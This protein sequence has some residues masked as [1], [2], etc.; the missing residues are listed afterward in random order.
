VPY[1]Q[2]RRDIL[3][4]QLLPGNNIGL[5]LA[6]AAVG[7]SASLAQRWRQAARLTT[8]GDR[9]ANALLCVVHVSVIVM[10]MICVGLPVWKMA[11]LGARGEAYRVSSAAHTWIFAA[12][13]LYWPW[14]RGSVNRVA[15]RFL[16]VSAVLL[17]VGTFIIA[18]TEAGSQFSPR[19][20]LAAVPLLAIVAGA[21][22]LRPEGIGRTSSLASTVRPFAAIV[23]LA[24][25]L[26]QASGVAWV[27][28]GKAHC[29][30]LIDWIAR[31]T[32]P[33]DVLISNVYWF[34]ELTATL[35][36]SRRMLFS[37]APGQMP[38]MVERAAAHG[39]PTF[40]IVT[41]SHLTGYDAPAAF[42]LPNARCRYTRGQPV[43]L[44]ELQ[45]VEYSCERR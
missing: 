35:A 21:A 36:P 38:A 26:M 31:G 3:V 29:A 14:F 8:Q 19:F 11:V 42:E 13:T 5:F 10:V 41:S 15:A 32:A 12:A 33:G 18:P 28:Y 30:R 43:T 4:A 24:S 44:G 16:I 37:W 7:L 6:A 39:F 40:R 17:I 34:P 23:I 45:I 9:P 22:L 25:L 27:K 1:V 2:V 20:F